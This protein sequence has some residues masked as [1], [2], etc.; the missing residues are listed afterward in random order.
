MELTIRTQARKRATNGHQHRNEHGPVRGNG[1]GTGI[2]AGAKGICINIAKGLQIGKT[3][4]IESAIVTSNEHVA[5]TAKQN[6]NTTV[7]TLIFI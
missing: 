7:A 1:T 3:I 5:V 2:I 6:N 4:G